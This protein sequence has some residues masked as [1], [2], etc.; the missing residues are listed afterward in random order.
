MV[1]TRDVGELRSVEGIEHDG[2]WGARKAAKRVSESIVFGPQQDLGAD[3]H[4]S[5]AAVV[6]K[7]SAYLISVGVKSRTLT[8]RSL[9]GW[10]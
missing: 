7:G 2:H 8:K 9:D 3:E 1:L 4:R 6:V 5:K 10:R